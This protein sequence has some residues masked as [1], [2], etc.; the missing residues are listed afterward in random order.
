M[1]LFVLLSRI[2]LSFVNITFGKALSRMTE[3]FAIIVSIKAARR[4]ICQRIASDKSNLLRKVC[5]L[6]KSCLQVITFI[7]LEVGLLLAIAIN[8]VYKL[9]RQLFSGH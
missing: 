5:F 3:T 1:L 9:A 2:L 7:L 4:G 6:L 8:S